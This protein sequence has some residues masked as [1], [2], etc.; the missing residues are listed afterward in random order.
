M[1]SRWIYVLLLV[2]TILVLANQAEAKKTR[3][4]EMNKIN[5]KTWKSGTLRTAAPHCICCGSV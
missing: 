3:V 2:A 4:K 1:L 5:A